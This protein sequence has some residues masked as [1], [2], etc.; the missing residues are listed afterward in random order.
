MANLYVDELTAANH[1]ADR[2][3]ASTV[4]SQYRC[5]KASVVMMREGIFYF[6]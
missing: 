1:P 6:F 5:I 3:V 4:D 2:P